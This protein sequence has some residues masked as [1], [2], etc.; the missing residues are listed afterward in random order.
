RD[1]RSDSATLEIE[2]RGRIDRS[3]RCTVRALDVVG[4]DLEL[5]LRVDART[6]GEEQIVVALLAVGLLCFGSNVHLAI[7]NRM[8][9]AIHDALVQLV[10]GAAL[11]RMND[12]GLVIDGLLAIHEIQAIERNV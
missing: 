5:R 8:R 2:Q 3:D 9:L 12:A 10:A 11:L 1:L 6:F 4:V 7:E